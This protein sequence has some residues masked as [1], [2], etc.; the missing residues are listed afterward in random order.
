MTLNRSDT[1]QIHPK[2]LFTEVRGEGAVLLHA[3]SRKYYSLNETGSIIWKGL[4][5]GHT[6][7]EVAMEVS[8]AFDVSPEHAEASVAQLATTLCEAELVSAVQR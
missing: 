5:D 4:R 7:Q 2:V 1:V 6:L 8:L 3:G